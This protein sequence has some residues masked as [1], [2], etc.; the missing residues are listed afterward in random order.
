MLCQHQELG[1]LDEPTALAAGFFARY[2]TLA[3]S[4]QI[5]DLALTEHSAYPPGTGVTIGRS[6]IALAWSLS[7][8]RSAAPSHF[9][10]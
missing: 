2:P 3:R 9:N 10:V 4:A 5:A 6:S 7:R 1:L 8:N